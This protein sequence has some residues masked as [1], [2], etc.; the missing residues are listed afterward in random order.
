MSGRPKWV[1]AHNRRRVRRLLDEL[2]PA[3]EA[4]GWSQREIERRFDISQR[5]LSKLERMPLADPLLTTYLRVAAAVGALKFEDAPAGM[6]PQE[7]AQRW[8]K[9]W[10]TKLYVARVRCGM[11]QRQLA[12]KLGV[13]QSQI[14][15]WETG[16]VVPC[17][18]TYLL[19]AEA[20][21]LRV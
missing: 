4:K 15:E 18:S 1:P 8:L 3:R 16:Q 2:R 17:L 14:S 12:D 10:L 7:L 9:V 13:R 20:V 19:V 6:T 11:T 21:D 5:T